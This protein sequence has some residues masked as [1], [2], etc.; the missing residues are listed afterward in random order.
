M[1]TSKAAMDLLTPENRRTLPDPNS[2][3]NVTTN[4][5]WWADNFEDASRRFKE[6]QLA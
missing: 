4:D 3:L 1:P 5:A 2:K 6:W